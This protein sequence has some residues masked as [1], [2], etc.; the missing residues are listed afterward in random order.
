[1]CWELNQRYY[2]RFTDPILSSW[3]C[4][5]TIWICVPPHCF[6]LFHLLTFDHCI[7]L[8]SLASVQ[9]LETPNALQSSLYDTTCC[10]AYWVFTVK[11]VYC[12][13]CSV[14]LCPVMLYINLMLSAHL[15]RTKYWTL[16]TGCLCPCVFTCAVMQIALVCSTWTG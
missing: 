14:S 15:C 5:M 8:V 1:M 9:C 4:L 16:L 13:C 12:L 11:C 2:H 10:C 3:L 7:L 6:F